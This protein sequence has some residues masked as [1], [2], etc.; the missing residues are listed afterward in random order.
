MPITP[1]DP[2]DFT[3]ARGNYKDLSPFRFWCQ[4]VLPLVYD[5]SLSYYELLNK[6]VN[7]LNLTMEDVTTLESDVTNLHTAYV[8]LQSYVNDYFESLDV[9]E[10]INNKL[11]EM[12]ENGELTALVSPLLPDIISAWLSEHLT[13]T[14]PPIDN[15]LTIEG[16]GADAKV[17]GEKLLRAFTGYDYAGESLPVGTDL[18][19]LI[20]RNGYYTLTLNGNYPNAPIASGRRYLLVFRSIATSTYT[21]QV[22][23]DTLTGSVY[24]RVYVSSNWSDWSKIPNT[25]DLSNSFKAYDY[26]GEGITAGTDLNTLTAKNGYYTLTYSGEYPNAPVASGRRY[27]LVFRGAENSDY[28]QQIFIDATNSRLY[29]RFYADNAWSNWKASANYDDVKGAFLSYDYIGETIATGTDLNTLT[30]KNG[31]YTLTFN[32]EYPN[33]PIASGRRYLLVFRGIDGSAFTQQIFID[34][35]TG[36]IYLRFFV[37]TSWSDWKKIPNETDLSY[38][39]KAYDYAGESLSAGTDLNTLTAK[40]GYYTLTYSGNYPNAPVASGRRYLLVFRGVSGSTFTHQIFV[41]ATKGNFYTRFYADNVWSNWLNVTKNAFIGYDYAGE[42]ITVGT[43][44]NTLTAKNGYYTLTY[45]GSYPNAPVASGRRYLLVFRSIDSSTYTQQLFIDATG[46]HIYLRFYSSGWSEWQKISNEADMLRNSLGNFEGRI[47]L[48]HGGIFSNAN[49]E[50]SPKAFKDARLIGVVYNDLDVTFTQ[51]LV[52]IVFHN[53]YGTPVGETESISFRNL[54]YAQLSEYRFGDENYS[55]KI[56]T[57]KEAY[58][59]NLDLGCK[60]GVDI[61]YV[62]ENGIPALLAYMRNNGI[63]VEY[64]ITSELDTFNLLTTNSAFDFPLGI[65]LTDVDSSTVTLNKINAILTMQN[66][67]HLDKAWAFF[68]R[69]MIENENDDWTSYVPSLLQAGISLEMYSFN[70]ASDFESSLPSYISAW[71]S[72]IYNVNYE[73]YKYVINNI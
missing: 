45:S 16:A 70:S 57:L 53:S 38:H 31:Y 27:L 50:N 11:D 55:W 69:G 41:D 66:A 72:A 32:G 52:P 48:S 19:D 34:T 62:P 18:D 25:R 44:L 29:T 40:N 8:Q 33:A 4:K 60:I 67:Q 7:Y 5:D 59:L 49:Y 15:T 2:A 22:F 23:I 10:E 28:T 51:D 13:P 24:L 21:Q 12:A 17:V 20:A 30:A 71:G 54:T 63:K 1:N 58:E 26:A 36:S 39:F 46:G 14:S 61:G 68:R 47:A 56:Q 6:V 65:V 3:P 9:Q 64:L 73:R 35:S 37:S 42:G 43:D